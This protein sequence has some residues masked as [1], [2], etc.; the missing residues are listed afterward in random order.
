M[1]LV[2]Y[3]TDPLEPQLVCSGVENMF[4]CIETTL[5]DYSCK[6]VRNLAHHESTVGQISDFFARIALMKTGNVI[7]FILT[8]KSEIWHLWGS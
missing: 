4:R 5:K 2:V 7:N 6:K 3:F 1:A 8:K